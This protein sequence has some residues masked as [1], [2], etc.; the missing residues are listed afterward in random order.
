[1][2]TN[3]RCRAEQIKN[4]RVENVVMDGP[5]VVENVVM[6]GLKVGKF[7]ISGCKEKFDE[8]RDGWSQN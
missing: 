1:M 5:T 4:D 6:D 2:V 3:S 8:G 7:G